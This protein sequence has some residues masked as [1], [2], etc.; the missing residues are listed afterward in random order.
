[1]D[2]GVT[3]LRKSS[4]VSCLP[5]T[6]W[7]SLRNV[8]QFGGRSDWRSAVLVTAIV[9]VVGLAY[10][11]TLVIYPSP[12]AQSQYHSW[13]Y[14]DKRWMVAL[15]VLGVGLVYLPAVMKCFFA[16]VN[17]RQSP[18]AL[19]DSGLLLFAPRT[20]FDRTIAA[21]A[22]GLL[23]ALIWAGPTVPAIL[24]QA[25]FDVHES[26]HL[27]AI[28]LIRQGAVPY[29]EAKTHFG[30]G[31]QMFSYAVMSATEFTFRGFR[32]A[33]VTANF[34][35]TWL[36]F[37]TMVFAF[38]WLTGLA[39]IAIALS[40]SPLVISNFIGWGVIFRWFGPFLAGALLPLMLWSSLAIVRR[41]AAISAVG[42]ACGIVAWFSNE[43]LI[44][45][46]ASAA[47]IFSAAIARGRL[48]FSYALLLFGGFTI[49]MV[50]TFFIL[51]SQ[52]VGIRNLF[53]ALQF[54]F[55]AGTMVSQGVSNT[56]WSEPASPWKWA[57]YCTPYL[58]IGIT[59]IALYN[60]TM[61]L[62]RE[63]Q[64]GQLLGM[65]AAASALTTVTMFRADSS[66]FVGP[67]VALAPLIVLTIFVLP[68]ALCKYPIWRHFV[69]LAFAAVLFTI[70]PLPKNVSAINNVRSPRTI[71]NGLAYALDVSRGALPVKENATMFEQRLGQNLDMHALCCGNQWT[72]QDY[73]TLL[74]GIHNAA[75]GRS[76]FIDH[77]DGT[78]ESAL[79]FLSDVQI[80]TS[81]TE[82]AGLVVAIDSDV[83]D[84][85]RELRNNPPGCLVTENRQYPYSQWLMALYAGRYTELR[86]P[87]RI[88]VSVIC[89]DK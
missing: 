59:A 24:N 82:P 81:F 77:I 87:G 19:T 8:F 5:S 78:Y 50:G 57:Y 73:A 18:L 40:I 72:N 31:H 7:Q 16:Q 21:S 45:T 62:R 80:G 33:H 71:F 39:T 67:S 10:V 70:Y 22:V 85:K 83:E 30:L 26:A 51:F 46:L 6:M 63:Q 41:F 36:L 56:A 1:M 38:G 53:P 20:W 74:D 4:L 14:L 13:G 44:L 55:H 43:N 11:G 47:L 37:A 3:Q 48:F 32:L 12:V 75:F 66:H 42:A 23:F 58:V 61:D 54:N 69:R 60:N 9:A 15:Y 2:N 29:V 64:L 27:G 88:K 86:I 79:Y 65:A 35:A 34:F 68:L 84:L 89:L 52:T 49:A 25:G 17:G 28:Q 76:I